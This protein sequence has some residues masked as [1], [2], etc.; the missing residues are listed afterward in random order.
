M[1][2]RICIPP[3]ICGWAT[4]APECL[5]LGAPCQLEHCSSKSERGD[6][7][8]HRF[9]P[10]PFIFK[11][12]VETARAPTSRAQVLLP[13]KIPLFFLSEVVCIYSANRP[14]VGLRSPHPGW[15]PRG[16]TPQM[17]PR[18]TPGSPS[19]GRSR[20]ALQRSH[21]PR[22]HGFRRSHG[23]RRCRGRQLCHARRRC[24]G[25][26]RTRGLQRS[27]GQSAASPQDGPLNLK[28]R[29]D[30]GISVW[31]RRVVARLGSGR[32]RQR[33]GPLSGRAEPLASL[34][35]LREIWRQ[36]P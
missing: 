32:S 2:F 28:R 33:A 31:I 7:I 8:L 10:W 19:I 17:D 27:H 16:H 35:L 5:R 3:V 21:G 14:Q 22:R 11:Q 4:S 15:P 9:G 25:L 36:H 6:S 26:L 1:R 30:E 29:P 12:F 13:R 23:L 24:H 18:S 20:H 34:L